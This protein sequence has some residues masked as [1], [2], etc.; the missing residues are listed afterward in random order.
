MELKKLLTT[1]RV[2][3]TRKT[4]EEAV[5]NDDVKAVDYFLGKGEGPTV[6]ALTD[7][8]EKQ[9]AKISA[10]RRY[11]HTEPSFIIARSL[12]AS[13]ATAWEKTVPA[14]KMNELLEKALLA[15]PGPLWEVA[16]AF[17]RKYSADVSETNYRIVLFSNSANK[18]YTPLL[19]FVLQN[20]LAENTVKQEI[21]TLVTE[22]AAYAR[23]NVI[24]LYRKYVPELVTPE[25]ESKAK[26]RFGFEKKARM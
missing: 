21:G 18:P 26:S 10:Q 8:L 11:N 24:D 1:T 14:K 7:A 23:T 12:T 22:A 15:S 13:L 6:K 4:F 5:E 3:F 9:I 2:F 20:K 19:E 17:I 16:E 25:I